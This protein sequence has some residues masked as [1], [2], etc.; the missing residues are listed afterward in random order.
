ML[1]HFN[2]TIG[3]YFHTNRV[4]AHKSQGVGEV[5]ETTET[6]QGSVDRLE[7]LLHLGNAVQDSLLHIRD[8]VFLFLVCIYLVGQLADLL[9]LGLARLLDVLHLLV[10][11]LLLF[12]QHLHLSF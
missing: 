5:L 7:T 2:V 8:F 3:D 4:A 11:L 12:L 6:R 10:S 9:R 1:K